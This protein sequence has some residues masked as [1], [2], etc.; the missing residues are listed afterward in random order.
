MAPRRQAIGDAAAAAGAPV[1]PAATHPLQACLGALCGKLLFFGSW[2]SSLTACCLVC[3]LFPGWTAV[4]RVSNQLL[5]RQGQLVPTCIYQQQ[6][7][8]TGPV[9]H[10]RLCCCAATIPGPTNLQQAQQAIHT[11]KPAAPS[12]HLLLWRG[13]AWRGITPFCYLGGSIGLLPCWSACHHWRLAGLPSA[14]N[15]HSWNQQRGPAWDGNSQLTGA[16]CERSLCLAAA[17][18]R[19]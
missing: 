9:R 10:R 1:V 13:V 19:A 17:A 15:Q 16:W 14:T 18:A 3:V 6:G 7:R 5:G 12:T 4:G 8:P 11:A 2:Y